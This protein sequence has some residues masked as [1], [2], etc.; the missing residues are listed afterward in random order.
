MNKFL[1][2]IHWF[3]IGNLTV[4]VCYATYMIFFVFKPEGVSGP[5]YQAAKK[6]PFEL[7]VTRRLYA[8]EYWVAFGALAIYLAITEFYPRIKKSQS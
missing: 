6:I 7:M 8:I 3:I 5:L 1:K 4:Q 2:V